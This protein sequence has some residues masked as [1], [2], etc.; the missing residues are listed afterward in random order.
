MRAPLDLTNPFASRT[1]SRV[2]R[3]KMRETIVSGDGK[4]TFKTMMLQ[5]AVEEL[6]TQVNSVQRDVA[7]LEEGMG[8]FAKD[9]NQR[10]DT[11]IDAVAVQTMV[12]SIHRA[13]EKPVT[14]AVGRLSPRQE[15]HVERV[16]LP[17]VPTR[18]LHSELYQK[19]YG[20][21]SLA[22]GRKKPGSARRAQTQIVRLAS[23]NA[24][25]PFLM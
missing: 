20:D 14:K 15:E 16:E 3:E 18:T 24:K 13:K 6:R 22:Q 19:V 4:G 7:K 1:R 23:A 12:D 25:D 9:A 11:K 21:E 8:H 5:L 17:V 10:I 2:E